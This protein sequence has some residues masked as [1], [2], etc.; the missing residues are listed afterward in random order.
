MKIIL[1]AF[2]S[3]FTI[4][5][6]SYAQ[7]NCTQVDYSE[8]IICFEEDSLFLW[9]GTSE[10]GLIKYDK[11]TQLKTYFTNT[12]SNIGSNKVISLEYYMGALVLSTDSSLLKFDNGSFSLIN[13]TINGLLVSDTNNHLVIA[14]LKVNYKND[15]YY[16]LEDSLVKTIHMSSATGAIENRD[17]TLDH[18]GNIW[19][20]QNIFYNVDII[21]LDGLGFEVFNNSNTNF[22]GP[23]PFGTSVC[24]LN[25]SL[26]LALY[27]GLYRYN[28]NWALKYQ[29]F[30]YDSVPKIT[31]GNYTIEGYVTAMDHDLDGLL[32]CGTFSND[33]ADP[34]IA[35]LNETG[36][37]I[38]TKSDTVFSS[39]NK[40]HASKFDSKNIYVG[41][42]N[43]LR[44]IDK[45]CLGLT[46]SVLYH[47]D[48]LE[49]IVYPNPSDGLINISINE[50]ITAIEV[51][52]LDGKR[53]ENRARISD[54][55][56]LSYLTPGIY[57]LKIEVS[58]DFLFQKVMIN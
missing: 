30:I 16:F 45:S 11:Q 28:G 55:I 19:L 37:H 40:I 50:P 44:I 14:D 20:V 10:N 23:N 12:N 27:D 51:L 47:E 36:W 57:I 24:S 26:Y 58:G 32:W 25:D 48:G 2:C 53:I 3:F 13:D 42:S 6:N 29:T 39:V 5:G 21:K 9:M 31:D 49:L 18:L 4:F 56:D 7:L 43:G 15:I 22:Q 8:N 41:T 35:Y 46:Q 33:S 17:L 1:F 34:E 52:A 54:Q 38:L